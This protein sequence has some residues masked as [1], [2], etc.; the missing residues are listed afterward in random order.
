MIKY[1]YLIKIMQLVGCTIGVLNKMEMQ[2]VW[3]SNQNKTQKAMEASF[4]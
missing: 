3:V 2:L 4:K 1:E